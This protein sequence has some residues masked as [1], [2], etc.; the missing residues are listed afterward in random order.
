VISP[1][2]YRSHRNGN[3][4]DETGFSAVAINPKKVPVSANEP[5]AETD[6]IKAPKADSD[7]YP[8]TARSRKDFAS[9]TQVMLR[10]KL[11]QQQS[12]SQ[13]PED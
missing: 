5:N 7:R 11:Q 6:P 3:K 1:K 9:L 4:S 12:P 2:S 13:V 8:G 10:P